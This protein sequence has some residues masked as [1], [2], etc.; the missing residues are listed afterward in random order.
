MS[1]EPTFALGDSSAISSTTLYTIIMIDTTDDDARTLHYARANFKYN[2]DI[3]K[4]ETQD[5]PLLEY[6]APGAFG[7][8]GDERKYSFL[9]YTNPQREEITE[10]KLPSEGEAFDVKQFQD[11]NGLQDASAGIGMVVKLGG[12]SDTPTPSD[13]PSSQTPE[14]SGAAEE[15][16]ST[17]ASSG[18]SATSAASEVSSAEDTPTP[19]PTATA[20]DDESQ[21]ETSSAA[22]GRTSDLAVAS[23]ALETGASAASTAFLTSAQPTAGSQTSTGGPAQQTDSGASGLSAGT[24]WVMVAAPFVGALLAW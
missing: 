7:E 4:I 14:S 22:A 17:P 3:V 11:D 16:S 12:G 6:K 20:T 21:D 24:A 15:A 18:A 5:Q 13:T 23:S 9:M 1:E 8:T 10:L 2:F 19:T